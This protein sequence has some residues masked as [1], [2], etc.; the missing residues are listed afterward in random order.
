MKPFYKSTAAL[1]SFALKRGVAGGVPGTPGRGAS[2]CPA[3]R[4]RR[5]ERKNTHTPPGF[6]YLLPGWEYRPCLGSAPAASEHGAIGAA[7]NEGRMAGGTGAQ[8]CHRG[9]FPAK[10]QAAAGLPGSTAAPRAA[11]SSSA[12][13]LPALAFAI[14]QPRCPGTPQRPL[15]KPILNKSDRRCLHLSRFSDFSDRLRFWI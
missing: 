14:A 1:A 11:G 6:R 10:R 4:P 12:G 7:Q 8:R 5:T 9:L 13:S 3:A 15:T 2:C